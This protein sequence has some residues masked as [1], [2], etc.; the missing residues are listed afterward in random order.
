MATTKGKHFLLRAVM[1]PVYTLQIFT[2]AKSFKAN[3]VIGSV[4]L[5]R[6]G[7]HVARVVLA[8]AVA[9]FRYTCLALFAPSAQRKAYARDGFVVLRDY[10]P[11][12][13][14]EA[15]SREVNNLQGEVRQCI[16]GDTLTQRILLNDQVLGNMP[17]CNDVLE[18][19]SLLGLLKYTS[20]KNTSPIFY[21]QNIK[22]NVVDAAA[23]PQR[24]LHSDT[25]HATMKAW[26]F[27]DDVSGRNGPFTYVP[28]S[29]RLTWK[30]LKWEYQNS[31][32]GSALPNSY[33]ARGSLRIDEQTLPEL[34]LPAPK[35]FNVPANTLVIANTNGFHRRGKAT[36]VSSRMEIWAY[37]R[38]NPFNPLPGFGF[39]WYTRLSHYAIT[40]YLARQDELASRK[41]MKASWHRVADNALHQMPQTSKQPTEKPL[42]EVA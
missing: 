31:I 8:A 25:F 39:K 15:L 32:Q 22:S 41:G 5:N 19:R 34:D 21:V 28:G 42:P 35:A 13:Q 24:T 20:A 40:R 10:L 37:S 30:R 14:F 4:L 33:A 27:L 17:V 38:T 12:E 6:L 16:Q 18:N 1:W 26:L 11:A 9:Q 23:D 29:H 2:G 36:D 3:P 7:L